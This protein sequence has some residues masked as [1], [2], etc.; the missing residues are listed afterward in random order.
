MGA[1]KEWANGEL[2]N[3]G[4]R[5]PFNKTRGGYNVCMP[6]V[7]RRKKNRWGAHSEGLCHGYTGSFPKGDTIW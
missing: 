4:V 1:G 7:V 5:N 6:E 3:L 2:K